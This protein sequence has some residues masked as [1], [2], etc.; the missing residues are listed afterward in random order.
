MSSDQSAARSSAAHTV[1]TK[2][3]QPAN[4]TLA[5]N[6]YLIWHVITVKKDT[7]VSFSKLTE[8][9]IGQIR[10]GGFRLADR[11]LYFGFGVPG[12][13]KK[14]FRLVYGSVSRLIN[15]EHIMFLMFYVYFIISYHIIVWTIRIFQGLQSDENILQYF[16][17]IYLRFMQISKK[18]Q[19]K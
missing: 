11:I 8:E 3:G 1:Q 16:Q 14:L 7:M 10:G 17:V 12:G 5:S 2:R 9:V 6:R 4:K 13:K 15:F 18:L 19:P